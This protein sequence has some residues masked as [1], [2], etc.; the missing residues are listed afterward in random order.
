MKKN[1]KLITFF[2]LVFD[3]TSAQNIESISSQAVYRIEV[4]KNNKILMDDSCVLNVSKSYSHFY[5]LGKIAFFENGFKNFQKQNSNNNGNWDMSG[6]KSCKL[7]YHNVYYKDYQKNKT[8][9]IQ[10][11]ISNTYA[12]PVDNKVSIN[13]QLTTDSLLI[14]NITCYKAFG[15]LDTTTYTAWYAPS[16]SIPDGPVFLKGLPGLIAQCESTNGVKISLMRFESVS[17]NN[18]QNTY[19]KNYE[20]T[21]YEQFKLVENKL[22]D[23]M[24]AGKSIELPEGGTIRKNN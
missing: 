21:T 14:N 1:I 11:L 19:F 24:N 12:Y 8:Y 7:C 5:S 9:A 13:W 16:I 4:N 18:K 20:F 3:S 17:N 6:I 22:K 23:D 2:L 10:S 15:K